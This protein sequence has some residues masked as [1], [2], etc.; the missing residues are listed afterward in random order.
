MMK[1]ERNEL[2]TA[3]ELHCIF[4]M[5][6]DYKRVVVLLQVRKEELLDYK[7]QQ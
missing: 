4:F 7:S 3:L 1:N 5:D 6:P 2:Q